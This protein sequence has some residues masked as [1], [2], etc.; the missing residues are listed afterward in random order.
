[1]ANTVKMPSKKMILPPAIGSYAWILEPRA[2]LQGKL[3]YSI[4]LIWPKTTDISALQS[5][6]VELA[7]NAFGPLVP[8]KVAST[9]D[10]VKKIIVDQL[11]AGKLKM[12]LHDG[13]IEHP[14][15]ENFANSWFLNASSSNPP[16]I[17]DAKL[18]PVFEKSE[19][20]SGCTFRASVNVAAFSNEAKGIAVYLNNLQVVKKGPRLDGRAAAEKEFAEFAEVG[21]S[22]DAAPAASDVADLFG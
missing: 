8:P 3:K 13:D 21:S 1:M 20:Y 12:P 16:G 10:A 15:D 11:K 19:C 18:Q 5:T 9:P 2:N 6:I 17:V 22:A 4:C 7:V 14:E